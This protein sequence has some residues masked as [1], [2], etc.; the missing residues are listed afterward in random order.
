MTPGKAFM[1]PGRQTD[2]DDDVPSQFKIPDCQATEYNAP[3]F[4]TTN[5][6]QGDSRSHE[7]LSSSLSH[8]RTAISSSGEAIMLDFNPNAKETQHK[9]PE[10]STAGDHAK[11]NDGP[12]SNDHGTTTERR[13]ARAHERLAV[14]Q[15][16][17]LLADERVTLAKKRVAMAHEGAAWAEERINFLEKQVASLERRV[18]AFRARYSGDKSVG[19]I[20]DMDVYP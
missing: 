5:L 2:L 17:I 18:L 4:T 11:S 14:A 8:F 20:E 7:Q 6:R 9:D 12:D 3:S 19:C 1:T 10:T 15:E 16:H 13:L